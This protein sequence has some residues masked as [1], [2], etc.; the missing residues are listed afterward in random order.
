MEIYFL[1]SAACLAILMLFYKLLLERENMHVFKRFYL[2][3]AVL[4]SFIIPWITFTSYV[5]VAGVPSASPLKVEAAGGAGEALELNFLLPVVLWTIYGFGILFFGVKFCRNFQKILQRIHQNPKVKTDQ[6]TNV[7]LTEEVTPHTFWSFIFLN[8]RKYEKGKI[9]PEVFEHER[10]HALQRHT[11]DILI[12]ELLQVIFWFH[13]LLYLVKRAIKLNHEFLA[14]RAVI[15]HGVNTSTYQETLLAFSSGAAN[16]SFVNSINYSSIKKRFIVMKAHTS[17]RRIWERSLLLLPL[18]ALLLYSFSTKKTMFTNL[19]SSKNVTSE[20]LEISID[21]KGDII[22]AGSAMNLHEIRENLE[23]G[24][25]TSYTIMAS[26]AAPEQ[27]VKEIIMAVARLKVEGTVTVCSSGEENLDTKARQ[28]EVIP[29]D[30]FQEKATPQMVAEYNK[31]AKHYKENEDDLV[32]KTVWERMKYIYSIMTAE[33][34]NSSEDFPSLNSNQVITVVEEKQQERS[35]ERKEERQQERA[36]IKRE[37]ELIRE[38]RIAARQ[39]REAAQSERRERI[40]GRRVKGENPPPPPPPAPRDTKRGEIPPPPPPAP[41]KMD[42]P[43]PPPPPPSPVEAVK[44]WMEE[45]ATFFYNGKAVSGKEALEAVQK[46]DGKN[47][48]VQVQENNSGKTVRISD[49]NK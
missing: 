6:V 30:D 21:E 32:E 36:A 38:E 26:P 4:V 22:F 9:P 13:P 35:V 34:K 43:M 41:E 49:N 48:N 37:R 27:V 3:S 11:L 12:M 16:S 40:I 45:G 24:D 14:D 46:N 28:S 19:A 42:V 15:N 18:M 10:A 47:L 25:Y 2:L 33:Q 17:K 23:P 20:V 8:Q 7:L 5:E 44:K 1:K 29:A 39:E 31:W